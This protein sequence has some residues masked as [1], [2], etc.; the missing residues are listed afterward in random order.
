MFASEGSEEDEDEIEE[1]SKNMQYDETLER[2]E[3]L[4]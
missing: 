2:M 4:N 1:E 3:R